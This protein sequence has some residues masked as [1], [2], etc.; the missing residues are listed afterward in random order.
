MF[1]TLIFNIMQLLNST[2]IVFFKLSLGKYILAQ[3]T[4]IEIELV[5]TQLYAQQI[6]FWY[7]KTS[8]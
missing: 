6:F 7:V 5:N 8:Y 3:S 2:K 4:V 1:S